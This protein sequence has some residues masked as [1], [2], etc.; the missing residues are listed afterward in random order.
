MINTIE[1]DIENSE[2]INLEEV[3]SIIDYIEN[4]PENKRIDPNYFRNVKKIIN[5]KEVN[6]FPIKMIKEDLDA[7]EEKRKMILTKKQN[8]TNE[9]INANIIANFVETSIPEAIKKL[10]WLGNKIKVIRPSLYDDYFRGIDNIIQILPDKIIED[11]KDLKCIGFSIDFTISDM[12]AEEKVFEAAL[13]IA[14]GKV[15]S[16]KYF[17]TDI[18][19]K[20]GSENIKI[21]DFQIPRIIISC[22]N[23]ILEE[24]QE[25]LLNFEKKPEDLET[26]ENAQDTTLRYYFIRECLTQLKFFAEVAKRVKNTVAYDVYMNSLESFKKILD[27]LGIDEKLLNKKIGKISGLISAFDL[28]ANNGQFVQ[29]LEIMKENKKEVAISI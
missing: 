5:G 11:K 8:L 22:P 14:K 25:D 2:E 12:A 23:K 13:A 18:M 4:L 10:D 1:K 29:L 9:E 6:V 15:P 7:V 26:R 21:K 19:T 17:N 28:D 3:I 27:E 16:I 24:S 20:H